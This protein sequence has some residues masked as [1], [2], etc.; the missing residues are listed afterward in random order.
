MEHPGLSDFSTKE[1]TWPFRLSVLGA[2]L[3]SILVFA[4]M[5]WHVDNT[6]QT[7][8][9]FMDSHQGIEDL[10]EDIV[11]LNLN[12]ITVAGD[13][14]ASGD[15]LP[16]SLR[17]RLT[18]ELQAALARIR[19]DAAPCKINEHFARA[20]SARQSLR[21]LEVQALT[22]SSQG[23][24][25]QARAILQGHQYWNT[26]DNFN[27]ALESLLSHCS[28]NW[29]RVLSQER[30]REI[31]TL[32]GAGVIFLLSMFTWFVLLR[33]VENREKRLRQEVKDRQRAG[34]EL[35]AALGRCEKLFNEA[36]DSIF[37]VDIS[38]G[39]ILDANRKAAERLGY[40]REELIG[41]PLSDID[42][43][44][45]MEIDN[46]GRVDKL[47]ESFTGR[48]EE[49]LHRCKNGSLL[50]MEVC[51]HLVRDG[52]ATIM[53]CSCRDVTER[54]H[55]EK[56]LLQAQKM[57]CVGRVASGIVHDFS[58]L[59][60]AIR[61]YTSIARKTLDPGHSASHPLEQVAVASDQAI[62]MSHTMLAFANGHVETAGLVEISHLISGVVQLLR[63][64]LPSGITLLFNPMVSDEHLWVRADQALLQQALL[65]LG[66]NAKEALGQGG[67]I[68]MTITRKQD[69]AVIEIRDSGEGIPPELLD[70]IW[71][72]FFTTKT[73]GRRTGLGLFN[74]KAALNSCHGSM[75]VR[76]KPGDGTC[77]SLTIPLA[78]V[79]DN[80]LSEPGPVTQE[81]GQGY[82]ILLADHHGFAR[83]VMAD[84]LRLVGFEVTTAPTAAA[85]LDFV[86]DHN[87]D[88]TGT[89]IHLA[90]IDLALINACGQDCLQEIRLRSESLPIILLGGNR[91]PVPDE[92]MDHFTVI[93]N[94]PFETKELCRLAQNVVRSREMQDGPV[95]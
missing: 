40:S 71:E 77:F 89:D 3:L 33:K 6:F 5:A 53:Q 20:D 51:N 1:S 11:H 14:V 56:Q 82:G 13:L 59:L 60:I 45:P 16:D 79:P 55:L 65:N 75:E 38:S 43:R 93:L 70:R 64:T 19:Q 47:L 94:K 2:A 66:L 72:P 34:A 62:A 85:L 54:N 57:E 83:E 52:D 32:A 88:R 31:G 63:P 27:S 80:L 58:N 18:G 49:R 29:A 61:G 95:K 37:L 76:S 67:K 86:T 30:K 74:V 35:A 22:L 24:I 44:L 12:I 36:Y 78:E 7:Y 69:S 41:K 46:V 50:T 28:S 84:S 8:R 10:R 90:I 42:L 21:A 92:G 15:G 91:E 4:P 87:F 25:N 17:N 23:E 48:F 9:T 68:E 39:C 26:L 81:L 73:D